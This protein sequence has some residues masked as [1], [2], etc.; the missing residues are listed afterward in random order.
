VEILQHSCQA[1]RRVSAELSSLV[2]VLNKDELQKLAFFDLAHLYHLFSEIGVLLY[3][4][5]Q[6]LINFEIFL[7]KRES[8][9][10]SAPDLAS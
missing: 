2:R 6:R 9:R 3:D 4:H 5:V 1:G 10:L 7:L 8:G